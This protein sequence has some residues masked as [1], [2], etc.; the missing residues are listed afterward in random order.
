MNS[1]DDTLHITLADASDSK[2]LADIFHA[3][4]HA[5]D[6]GLYSKAAQEAWAPTP[7][8]YPMWQ[9]RMQA[10]DQRCT[11]IAC[12]AGEIVAFMEYLPA[13]SP[14][15]PAQQADCGY[16]DCTYTHPDHQ[17]KGIAGELYR[18]LE[19]HAQKQKTKFLKVDASQA[20]EVFFLK[21]GFTTGQENRIIRHGQT[22]TNVSMHKTLQACTL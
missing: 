18:H 11:F 21:R 4:V 22:L 6:P 7:P 2:R 15:N 8:D 10:E 14:A 12:I 16:I 1:A 13:G 5:I 20:A 9:S 17:G 19:A 3:A